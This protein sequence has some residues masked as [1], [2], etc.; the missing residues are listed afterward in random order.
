MKKLIKKIVV[1]Y[2]DY[3]KNIPF[4]IT[5]R[6]ININ[7]KNSYTLIGPRRAGKTI[8][9]ISKI[10][11]KDNILYIN[12]EDE[13]LKEL[14]YK[15]LDIIIECYKELYGNKPICF[16]DEIHNV[17]GWG[18]FVRRLRDQHYTVLISGSNSRMLSKEIGSVLGARFIKKEVL[19][20]SLKEILRINNIKPKKSTIYSKEKFKIKKLFDKYLKRGGLPEIYQKKMENIDLEEYYRT[21]L[22][23]ILFKDIMMRYSIRNKNAL[24]LVIKKIAENSGNSISI[25]RIK[26]LLKSIGL[27]IGKPTVSNYIRYLKEAFLIFECTDYTKSFSERESRKKYYFYDNGLLDQFIFR[28]VDSKLV[29]NLVAIELKRRNKDMFFHRKDRECDFITKDKKGIN[30]AIQVTYELN[31]NN[32]KRELE[33]LI[34]A[35]DEY[36]LEKGLILTYEQEDNLKKDGKEIIVKPIWKWILEENA[37]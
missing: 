16:F 30:R 3:L 17:D 15:D 6:D 21:V 29:E 8:L 33:G 32:R 37:N 14:T 5:K 7:L 18:K 23:T 13:R 24:D 12:F 35:L 10:R 9:G 36:R 20:F 27:K 11:N 31:T 1:E 25:T 34:E 22:D 2:R 28:K 4:R 26:N 19:P